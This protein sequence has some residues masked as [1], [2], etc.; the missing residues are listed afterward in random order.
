[1]QKSVPNVPTYE[2][3]FGLL[4]NY[5]DDKEFEADNDD[6]K[7]KLILII[8]LGL[9]EE[10]YILHM[11]DEAYYFASE[12]FREDIEKFNNELKENLLVLFTS[13][14]T[15]VTAEYDA[16]WNIPTNEVQI[17]IEL[18][19]LIDSGIDSVVM[20]LYYDLKDKADFYTGLSMTTGSFSPHSNFRRAIRKLTNQIDYK[21]HH[22]LKII[23][24]KYNE[25]IYGQ[26]AL[27]K[28]VCSGI[29][30]CEWCYEIEAKSPMPLSWFPV[31]H[32]NGRCKLVPVNP[33][34]YSEEYRKVIG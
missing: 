12:Q 11:Y 3:F 6:E 16:L 20:M 30:T 24:R 2:E 19:E 34:E 13:F 27:F 32:I 8:M 15:E 31:D 7:L 33:D 9:V 1:M 10:F 25:F 5:L 21:G 14:I 28:W 23:D 22:I 26:D 18:E 17:A 29:N 4:D